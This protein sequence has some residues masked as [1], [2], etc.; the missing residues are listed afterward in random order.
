MT[1][2]EYLNGGAHITARR[3]NQLPQTKLEPEQVKEIRRLHS[4]KQEQIAKLNAEFSAK[5]LASKFG[6]HYRTIEK[7]LT[8]ETHGLV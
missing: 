8:R 4:W 2:Y 7:V 3:S 6:V 1:R 5:G